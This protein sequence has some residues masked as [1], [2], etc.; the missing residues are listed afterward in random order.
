MIKTR[1]TAVLD[2]DMVVEFYRRSVLDLLATLSHGSFVL[3][4]CFYPVEAKRKVADWLGKE[5]VYIPQKGQDLGE[6]MENGFLAAFA[7][8]FQRVVLIGSDIPDLPGA[9]LEEAISSLALKDAV[10]GPALDGGYYLIGFNSGRFL[11]EAFRGIDW[12]TPAVFHR[13]M[14]LLN[15]HNYEVRVL[16]NGVTLTRMKIWWPSCATMT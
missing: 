14:T 2:E 9:I 3:R 15:R 11:A 4:I 6:R 8:G 1:L 5:H 12:G 13:T 16:P 7:E 10:L